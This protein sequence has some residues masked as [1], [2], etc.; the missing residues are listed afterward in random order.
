MAV[1]RPHEEQGNTGVSEYP[2]LWVELRRLM[3]V[4]VQECVSVSTGSAGPAGIYRTGLVTIVSTAHVLHVS[5]IKS[6]VIVFGQAEELV[7]VN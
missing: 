1:K 3:C 6:I 2:T 5:S 7:L 4:C